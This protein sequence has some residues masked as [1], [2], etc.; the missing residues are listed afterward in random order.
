MDNIR[1]LGFE[2]FPID[3]FVGSGRN[4]IQLFFHQFVVCLL[5]DGVVILTETVQITHSP[6]KLF[7]FS[8]H[9][10][11]SSYDVYVILCSIIHTETEFVT[12]IFENFLEMGVRYMLQLLP[13]NQKPAFEVFYEENFNRVVQY[14]R[15]KLDNLHDAEDLASDIFLYCYSHYDDYDPA[16]SSL[17]TWL[18]LIVN[19][20]I[21]NYYRDTKPSVDLELLEGVLQDES[22]DMDACIYLQQLQDGLKRAM[23]KLP[24]RQRKIVTMRY[25]EERSGAEIAERLG[26]TPGNVR[27]Q[28]SRAL[29]T[30]E[31]LCGDLLEGVR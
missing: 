19:S 13:K 30:L 16:K 28:L 2:G 15:K 3:G 9:N 4:E 23:E 8:S 11:C 14:I 22:I 5:G 17:T 20:R 31:K 21:K 18:Y 7:D 10:M 25:F 1:V 6:Q 24:E 27:V 26:M 12:K 29:D